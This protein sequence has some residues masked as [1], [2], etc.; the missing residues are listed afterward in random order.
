MRA[1]VYL[2]RPRR[3]ALARHALASHA[4]DHSCAV[5]ARGHGND[6]DE[7]AVADSNQVML[8]WALVLSQL[9]NASL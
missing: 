1:N 5:V 9:A 8:R 4:P 6:E 7:K 2:R 3:S